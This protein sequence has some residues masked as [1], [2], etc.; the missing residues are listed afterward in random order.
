MVERLIQ[1]VESKAL[2]GTRLSTP[3]LHIYN[4]VDDPEFYQ[5]HGHDILSAE[6]LSRKD[7][8]E[9]P[10]ISYSDIGQMV[11]ESKEA[12]EAGEEILVA[13]DEIMLAEGY[14]FTAI[15][16]LSVARRHY[17]CF[18]IACSQR[19]VAFPKTYFVL[20]SSVHLGKIDDPG[21]LDHVSWL[22]SP[23]EKKQLSTAQ[24]GEFIIKKE[25]IQ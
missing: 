6:G 7:R 25:N 8:K 10:Y 9:Y 14:D 1:P 13:I 4:P 3:R 11:A 2:L 19:P 21:E 17:N 5:L 24:V 18:V 12:G 22:V 20:A 16:K 23:D 15:K